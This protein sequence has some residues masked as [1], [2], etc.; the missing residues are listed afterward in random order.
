[1]LIEDDPI[2]LKLLS[3][4]LHSNAIVSTNKLRR[5]SVEEIKARQ[6]K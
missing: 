4:V 2:D 3:A 6:P 5:A 1:M